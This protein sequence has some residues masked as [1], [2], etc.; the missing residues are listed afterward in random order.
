MHN[1]KE[2]NEGNYIRER[3]DETWGEN[4]ER[5]NEQGNQ[6]TATTTTTTQ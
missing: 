1:S 4:T 3:H 5:G 2:V 6:I